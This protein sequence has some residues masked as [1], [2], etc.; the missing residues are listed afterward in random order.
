MATDF[1]QV[2]T[3]RRLI[4][5]VLPALLVGCITSQPL[6][7]GQLEAQPMP[8]PKVR[9]PKV[10]QEWVYQVRNVFNEEIVDT[11]TERVVSVGDQIR[12]SRSG[13]KAGALPDEI[14]SPWGYVIQDPHW[15][16]PQKF[17]KAMPL[18]PEQLQVG[19]NKFFTSQYE[20][21]S[22]TGASYYWGLGM[23]AN[24]W[25]RI[26]SPAGEFL[27]LRIH[28]EI[29]N[30]ASNDIFRVAN[31]RDEEL[32]FAPE[33]GRWVVRRSSGRYVTLGVFWADA[34]WEDYLE[35]ELISWK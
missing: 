10:G 28:N 16:P 1:V 31:A 27:V 24:Q 25:E 5:M 7:R 34:Y 11:I 26:K 2:N 35:W 6:P 21:L 22:Y 14:Q 8:P 13:V 19:W 3:L 20:V 15:Q 12:I 30:F 23:T 4:W 32:W 29:P 9:A 33:I 18:W 17:S